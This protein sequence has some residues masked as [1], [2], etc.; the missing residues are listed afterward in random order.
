MPSTESQPES[1]FAVERESM[2]RA[3][4][5]GRIPQAALGLLCCLGLASCESGGRHAP[6][7]TSVTVLNHRG[8]PDS[9]SLRN[10]P[11]EAIV[12]PAVGRVMQFGFPG[13]DG[14]FWENER[15]AGAPIPPKPWDNPGSF[16]GDKTWPAPQSAWGWPPPAV[17]DAIPLAARV[18]GVEVIL[19]SPVDPSFGIRTQRRIALGSGGVM[20]IVT[21]YEKI[22]GPPVELSVWVITQLKEPERVFIPVPEKSSFADG[23]NR[24][25][26]P[27]P[28]DLRKERGLISLTRRTDVGTKIGSDAGTLIWVGARHVLR[29]DAPRIPGGTYPDQGSSVEVYTNPDPAAYVELET[30]GPLRRLNLGDRISAT[31]TYTLFRRTRDTPE[32]EARAHLGP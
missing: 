25:S 18:D 28:R 19:T 29:I 30:L 7:P 26:E 14:V 4:F 8:W 3:L 13:E 10:G 2:A 17:Y 15:L 1:T 6:P 16:G 11:V 27:A 23:Y 32:A 24:Q 22:Q 21:T 12:V 9:Y 5:L 20:R 31:N